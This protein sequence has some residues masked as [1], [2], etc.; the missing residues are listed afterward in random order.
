MIEFESHRGSEATRQSGRYCIRRERT[1]RHDLCIGRFFRNNSE[2][3]KILEKIAKGCY[4]CYL[5][6][7]E[8]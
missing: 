8:N 3:S 1:L 7:K 6:E 2:D 5:M 4:K